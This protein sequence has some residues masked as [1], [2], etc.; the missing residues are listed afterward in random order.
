MLVVLLLCFM[1]PDFLTTVHLPEIQFGQHQSTAQTL[2]IS[3]LL[4]SQGNDEAAEK[5]RRHSSEFMVT[6]SGYENVDIRLSAFNMLAYHWDEME[7]IVLDA[8][9]SKYSNAKPCDFPDD[10]DMELFALAVMGTS[11]SET[12]SDG[13]VDMPEKGKNP[14]AM[15]A[16]WASF[17][18]EEKIAALMNK[19]FMNE[20][21]SDG[22]WQDGRANR[23]DGYNGVKSSDPKVYWPENDPQGA[24]FTGKWGYGLYQWTAKR[25]EVFADIWEKSG[26]DMS[27]IDGQVLMIVAEAM[28]ATT[29][30][31]QYHRVFNMLTTSNFPGGVNDPDYKYSI[32]AFWSSCVRGNY[33]ASLSELKGGAHST[34]NENLEL[35]KYAVNGHTWLEI[36]KAY[37]SGDVYAVAELLK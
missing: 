19:T 28:G 15:L 23:W 25:R 18:E 27:K 4:E 12:S 17:S 36:Y 30:R 37:I 34:R 11:L 31:N 10:V 1:W 9:G 32:A 26:Y 33:K 6:G 14:E 29:W 16:E 2:F 13:T 21:L 20:P 8:I 5:E 35:S 7:K 3:Q 24:R 22:P